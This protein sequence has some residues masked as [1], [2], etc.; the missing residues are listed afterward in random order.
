VAVK[1]AAPFPLT[2]QVKVAFPS[3]LVTWEVEVQPPSPELLMRTVTPPGLTSRTYKATRTK[4]APLTTPRAAAPSTTTA[5]GISLL[6][7]ALSKLAV[8]GG[9]VNT[10]PLQSVARFALSCREINAGVC[11]SLV[12]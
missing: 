11:P 4:G 12:A 9:Q 3:A 8:P 5:G 1:M 6:P 10:T 2:V 7:P